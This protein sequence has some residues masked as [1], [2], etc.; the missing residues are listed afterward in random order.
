[1]K[2]ELVRLDEL[3]KTTYEE[4]VLIASQRSISVILHS[5]EEATILG[6]EI[7]LRRM[8]LNLIDNAVKY[9]HEHGTIGISLTK[10]DGKAIIIINDSG[11]GIP[12]NEVPRIFDRFYRVDRARSREM[13]GSGLG[14]AIVHWIVGAHGGTIS[15]KS[16]PNTGS[17]F[18]VTFPVAPV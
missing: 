3:V 14:L 10:R 18:S 17:E 8:L 11:I 6:E 4:S 2:R 12:A 15:V 16:D 13:G 9:N 1:V 7:R 5:V